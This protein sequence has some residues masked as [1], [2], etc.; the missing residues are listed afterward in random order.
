LFKLHS[1]SDFGMESLLATLGVP[2]SRGFSG[3]PLEGGT[4]N[5]TKQELLQ[6]TV[7]L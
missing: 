2:R 5:A 3:P 4:P 6:T 1:Y 7:E